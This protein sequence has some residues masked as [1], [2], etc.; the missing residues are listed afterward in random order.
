MDDTLNTADKP[1]ETESPRI[2]PGNKTLLECDRDCVSQNKS[3][4]HEIRYDYI[5]S[6]YYMAS[7]VSG[8]DESNPALR[9]ASRAERKK[10]TNR[11]TNRKKFPTSEA[12]KLREPLPSIMDQLLS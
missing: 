6:N 8:K 12:E 7:S 10:K 4:D 1:E 11:V 3:V 5:T 9:L 2:T